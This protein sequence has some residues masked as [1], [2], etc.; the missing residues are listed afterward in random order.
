MAGLID[1]S[2][3]DPKG[4]AGNEDDEVMTAAEALEIEDDYNEEYLKGM[5]A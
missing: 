5:T 3:G 1:Y 2:N 4:V